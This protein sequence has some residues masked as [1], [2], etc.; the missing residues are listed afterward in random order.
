MREVDPLKLY[1]PA[2]F[3]QMLSVGEKTASL[4]KIARKI[5]AQYEKEVEYS[6][7]SLTKW[8]EPLAIL[9]A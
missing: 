5:N 1:F 4:E 7:S 3:T 9:L 8:I 6:L 2:D